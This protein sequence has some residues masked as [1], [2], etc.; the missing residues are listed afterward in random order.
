MHDHLTP[1]KAE[2]LREL[3]S[4]RQALLLDCGDA[5]QSPNLVAWPWPERAIRLMNR[6]GYDAMCAGNR[7]Y[8]LTRHALL[9]KTAAAGFPVLSANLLPR[10]AAAPQFK[11]WTILRSASGVRVGVFGLTEPLIGLGSFWER[12]AAYRFLDPLQAAGEAV[13]ALRGQV[14]LLV[15]LT[16]YGQRDEHKLAE[17]FPQ[18]DAILCGH[19]HVP[20]PSLQM[21][22]RTALSRTFH[23][24]QGAAILTF[25]GAKWV[26]ETQRL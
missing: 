26:Q 2:R 25:D 21:I 15:A 4:E 9:A 13:G 16:H 5:L 8:G 11:R 10:G 17:A 3:K 18:I 1:P 22:G 14:D 6:A 19:W 20:E 23:Y 12:L 24:A 7:E